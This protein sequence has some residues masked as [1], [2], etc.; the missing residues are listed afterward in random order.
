MI[1]LD[2]NVLSEPLRRT[3]NANVLNWLDAQDPTNLYVPATVVGEMMFGAFSKKDKH[4]SGRLSQVIGHLFEDLYA[5]R[6]LPYDATAAYAYGMHVGRAKLNGNPIGKGD[7]Q[8]AAIAISNN[9]APVATRDTSP[10][11][12]LGV[13]VIDPWTFGENLQS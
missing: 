11:I 10:F 13:D 5:G 3:P 9:Y 4:Q 12:Q 6:I 2:T 7:G 1:I 8:I